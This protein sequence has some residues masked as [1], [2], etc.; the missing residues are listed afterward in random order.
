VDLN[1]RTESDE[2]KQRLE[3][4][5]PASLAEGQLR[6]CQRAW[7]SDQDKKWRGWHASVAKNSS[8][9][10]ALEMF[11][12]EVV[13]CNVDGDNLITQPFLHTLLTSAEKMIK[14]K[15]VGGVSPTT[16]PD[17]VGISF[18][19]PS[20]PSTTGRVALGGNVFDALGGYDEEFGPSG[21]QDV[22]L[23][24]RLGKMGFHRRIESDT[25]VGNAIWNHLEQCGKKYR[26]KLEVQ[27]KVANVSEEFRTSSWGDL[28]AANVRLMRRKL[29]D[30]I[31]RRNEGI[32]IGVALHEV[33]WGANSSAEASSGGVS[34]ETVGAKKNKPAEPIEKKMPRPGS[35]SSSSTAA[36]P[37]T[38]AAPA[39]LEV[40]S[41]AIFTFGVD[42]LAGRF[43]ESRTASEIRGMVSTK[44]GPPVPVPDELVCPP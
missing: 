23:S 21:G 28:D 2:L 5:I 44:G 41:F 26:R 12:T 6:Y 20:T 39:P 3:K 25:E 31:L 30:G 33:R 8:H 9:C 17:I 37:M 43:R 10:A 24:R 32:E 15:A 4:H 38:R 19:A 35:S 27:A 7:G 42:K 29:A 11:G 36:L 1:D 14:W 18:K 34:P 16:L 13:L 22:D 40:L